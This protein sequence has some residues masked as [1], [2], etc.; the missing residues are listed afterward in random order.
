[1]KLNLNTLKTEIEQYLEAQH[2]V[3]FY[4][5]SPEEAHATYWDTRRFPD[6]QMFLKAAEA[7]GVRMIVFNE[8]EFAAEMIDDS[9]EHLHASNLDREQQRILEHRLK[10]MR[11][12]DGFICALELSFDLNGRLYLFDLRTDWYEDVSDMLDEIDAN[13]AEGEEE[14]DGP[15]GGYFSN[16]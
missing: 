11:V 15:I 5:Y 16:N 4:G 1:M 8:R 12:Y 13:P 9:L 3:V 10:E 14:D 6:Y 2:F 7:A